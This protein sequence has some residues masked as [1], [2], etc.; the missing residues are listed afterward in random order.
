MRRTC[1]AQDEGQTLVEYVLVIGIV[2][3]ALIAALGA[4]AGG[5]GGIFDTILQQF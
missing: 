1:R 2:S 5:L 4:F 3:V